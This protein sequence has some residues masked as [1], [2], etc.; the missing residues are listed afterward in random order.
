MYLLFPSVPLI[1]QA[2]IMLDSN[3]GK[4]TGFW[5][6]AVEKKLHP[7]LSQRSLQIVPGRPY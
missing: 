3:R 2:E 5:P 4:V 6:T 7:V 1:K